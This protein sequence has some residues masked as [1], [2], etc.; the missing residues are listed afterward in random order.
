LEMVYVENLHDA[1]YLD[2][3]SEVADY[4]DLWSRLT[5]DALNLEQ[6]RR[7]IQ[8]VADHYA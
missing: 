1:E 4:A 2:G 7:F 3:V 6:S 8:G 5:A